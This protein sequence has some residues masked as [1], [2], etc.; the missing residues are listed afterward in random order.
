MDFL[1]QQDTGGNELWDIFAI[2]SD[3]GEP[4]NVTNTPE[5]RE[6]GPRWSPDGK[7]IALNHK[8]KESTVY[9][10]ALLDWATRKV[11]LLTHEDTP[12]HIWQSV[13]WRPNGKTLYANR[14]EVS[15]T[16]ANV[17]AI[18]VATA[19]TTNLTAHQGQSLNVA[20]SRSQDGKTLLLTSNQKG[21]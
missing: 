10:I 12:K 11:T 21:G 13:A 5:I 1:Y 18:D 19:K 9:N 20:S 4:I 3:G 7:T 15:F 14:L 17:Y 8:P 6:E 2:P 16:D